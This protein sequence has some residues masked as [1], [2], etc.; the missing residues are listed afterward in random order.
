MQ[1]VGNLQETE[2][3]VLIRRIARYALFAQAWTLPKGHTRSRVHGIIGD[4]EGS[5]GCG[6]LHSACK[7]LYQYYNYTVI[8]GM[9]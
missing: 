3:L 5:T 4:W 8:F 1:E 9:I 2:S 7:V 6:Q